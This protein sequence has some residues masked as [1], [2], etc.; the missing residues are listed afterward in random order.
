VAAPRAANRRFDFADI[1]RAHRAQLESVVRLNPQQRRVLTDIARCRTA[2]LGGHIDQCTACGY[3]HP[4][5]NSCRN[6]HCPK[7]QALAQETWIEAERARL[8]DVPHFHVVFTLPAELRPL[9]AFARRIVF[10]ALFRVAASTLAAFAKSRLGATI[11]ATLVLH[12]W[13]RKLQFHP[14]VHAIVTGGGLSSDGARWCAAHR[15]FLF[16]VKAMSKVFRAKM[17]AALRRA[18]RQGRFARFGDFEDPEGFARLARAVMKLDWHIYAKPSFAR[19]TYVVEYLGRYTHRV[20]L[21]NSRLLA[22]TDQA[23]TFRTKGAATTTIDPVT[24]LRRFVQHVLPIGFH[25]IRHV[26]LYASRPASRERARA[27]LGSRVLPRRAR[28]WRERLHALT[29]RDVAR[30]PLCGSPMT[31]GPLPVARAPPAVAA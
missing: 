26:G 17:L 5:Y 20:G 11:G 1:V 27:L 14:H 24:L 16:P 3:E 30:C 19:G 22:V 18:Y 2:A 8:L 12:T 28:S 13:T 29:R 15:A 31:A 6:R 23:V 25:K 10:D 4:S 7:C 9:A 21:A